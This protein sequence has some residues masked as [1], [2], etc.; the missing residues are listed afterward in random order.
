M[1]FYSYCAPLLFLSLAAPAQGADWPM[2][3]CDASRS[4]ASD[5]ELA[6]GLHLVWERL[7]SARTMVWDDPLNQDLMPYDRVFEP[8][9]A[10]KRMFVGFNDCDKLVALDT[11]TG[12]QLWAYYTDG[13]VRLPPVAWGDR[14]YVASDDGYLY[15][16]H[17]ADGSLVWKFRGGPS[18]KKIIGNKRL[19]SAWP[20]RGGPV[21]RDGTVYFTASIWPMMGTFIY[22]LDAST[23]EVEWENDHTGSEYILQPHNSPAFAGVAPQG[24]LAATGKGLLVPGGRSVPAFF[25][26]ASGEQRYFH[27]SAQNKT[28]G[29]FVCAGEQVFFNHHR[30]Q[31]CSMYDLETGYSLVRRIGMHPVLTRQAFY[32]AGETLRAYDAAQLQQKARWW[33]TGSFLD[34]WLG[35]LRG[36]R[37]KPEFIGKILDWWIE[38][39]SRMW[40]ESLLWE[41]DVDGTFDL[42]KAGSCLYAAGKEGIT[43]I[44]LP[45]SPVDKPEIIWKKP[46]DGETGR[47]LAADDKLFAVTLDGRILAFGPEKAEP[48]RLT[49]SPAVSEPPVQAARRALTIIRETGVRDGYALVYGV[50]DGSFLEAL[51]GNSE[52]VIAAVDQDSAKIDRLRRNLDGKGLYGKRITL[53]RGSVST[54][55]APPYMASLTVVNIPDTSGIEKIIR[56]MRPYGGKAWLNAPASRKGVFSQAIDKAQIHGIEIVSAGRSIVLTRE[57][58]LAGAAQWTHQY[59]NTANTVKSDDELVK[60]PLGILWFGGN[61]NMDVLPRHGHGPPEQ[62][63]GGRL[64]IQGMDCMSARDVYTGRVLWKTVLEELDTYGIY[65]DGSYEDA[66]TSTA[67]NQEHLPGANIRGTNFVA[68]ADRVYLAQD[69]A[70]IVLEAATGQRLANIPLP[71]REGESPVQWGYIGVYDDLLIAGSGLVK[72][73]TAVPR[74]QETLEKLAGLPPHKREA[75]LSFID[76]DNSA[77]KRLLVMDRYSGKVLWSFEADYGLLHNGIVAADGNIFCLD[78]LP[79]YLEKKL[80]RRG[81]DSAPAG[82]LLALDIHTG[83][84]LWENKD[85]VFGSWLSF[86]LEHDIL[87]QSTRPSRDMV[88]GEEGQRMIAYAAHSGAILWDD[89][90]SYSSVPILHSD[91]IITQDKMLSLLT[92]EPLYH[93]HPLTGERIPVSWKRNYGCNYPIASENLITFR[94]AAAGFYDLVG[95]SGT[96]NFGGFKSGCTS[97]LIAADGVLNAPDYTRTC[98]CSYQ[99][100]TSLALVHDPEVEIWTFNDIER[101]SEPVKRVGINFGAPGDRMAADGT[102]WL[103]YPSRG[104]PSP[105]IPLKI[106]GK[107]AR[108]FCHHSSRIKGDGLKWVAASGVMGLSA[109][110]LTL[111]EKPMGN[112]P[113]TVRLYFAECERNRPQ[114]RIFDVALQGRTVLENFNPAA[115]AG[116]SQDIIVKEF[117][118]IPVD[119]NLTVSFPPGAS[120]D[121]AEPLICGIEVIAETR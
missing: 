100:Q 4:A 18:E 31:V 84:I 65:Y 15:C 24:A 80:Q 8:V 5:Q 22:A 46:V 91:M 114:S 115:G 76:F 107:G 102:L 27:L 1:R 2:W 83:R 120:S 35:R 7:Y 53:H 38:R 3:R 82:R 75:M 103:D 41:I 55:Q 73:S 118:E 95:N 97:N 71:A 33:L 111:A 11:D 14:V 9:V 94:S 49:S 68:T 117:R 121:K 17:A 69:S 66:P 113:Y 77:S 119:R 87:L 90:V 54:F 89:S 61:S 59:G 63:V 43:A 47:L 39:K 34:R 56:S 60:L 19:I 106:S 92:G 13:P 110:T 62:V 105:D 51:A 96:G 29:S 101:G 32:I 98:A 108:W 37:I 79:P 30:D 23:G 25:E 72:F 74:D 45:Q 20:A 10:G 48:V 67:Y 44:R 85:N 99:N 86:S 112:K 50:D 104:G 12:E 21:I 70:C 28:G 36:K 81:A 116:E 58:P 40:R 16:L 78:K 64:F 26:R 93:E 88:L 109:V 52:L 6:A 57:G 42:I